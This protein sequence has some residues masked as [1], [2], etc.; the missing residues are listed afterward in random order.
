MTKKTI[1]TLVQDVYAIF[2]DKDHKISE[3]NLNTL[4]EAVKAAVRKKI[5]EAGQARAPTLRMSVIG[6]P[7][8][9]LWYELRKA[10]PSKVVA[11]DDVDV[12]EPHPEKFIKFLFGDLIE[13]LLIFFIREAGHTVARTQEE[14]ELNGVLGHLDAVVDGV[15]SDFKS[16]SGYQFR[17]KFKSGMLLRQGAENDPFGY[18]GQLSGYA[19]KLQ[20]EPGIDPDRVAW[21]VMNKESGELTTLFADS[22]DMINATERI[23]DIRSF[24]DKDTPPEDKCYPEEFEGKSGNKVLHKNCSYCAFKDECWKDAN[25]GNGLRKFKYSNGVKYF[26]EVVEEPRVEELL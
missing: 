1:D 17:N 9:Q 15:V 2:T 20:K 8:R 16:A 10:D 13:A 22:F 19:E 18:I 5:E 25:G 23:N 11:T 7:D 21:I 3:D 24:L 12:F 26:T 6:K 4:G 14:I